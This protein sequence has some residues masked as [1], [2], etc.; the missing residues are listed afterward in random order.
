MPRYSYHARDAKGSSQSGYIDAT[1]EADALRQL[2]GEGFTVTDI[3]IASEIVDVEQLRTRQAARSVETEEVIAFS[4]QMSV[5]LET[6]VPVSEALGAFVKQSK[7][8]GFRRVVDVVRDRINSGVSFSGAIAEFPRAFPPMMVCLLRASEATGALGTMLGRV[9]DYLGKERRTVKQIKGA[10]TYPAVMVG[11]AL[12]V[13]GFLVTWVLPR[14]SRIYESRS[15]TLPAPTR[16]LMSVSD[17]LINQWLLIAV[18]IGALGG[19]L[20]LIPKTDR[21]RYALDWMKVNA[22]IIGPIFSNFYLSRSARTL[23]TLLSAGVNL[24]EAVQIVRGVT[25]NELWRRFWDDMH[26]AMTSGRDVSEVVLRSDL[27][28][29]STAQMIAAGEKSGR[30]GDVLERIANVTEEDLDES[31]KNSTQ[32]IEPL[33]I[34]FMG[35][36]IGGIAIALLLPIFS[37]GSVMSQ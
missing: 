20:Y 31:I 17:A 21:G 12:A 30:L 1:T 37:M 11:M 23:G 14:F 4:A 16:I 27:F 10:L 35:I 25:N 2:R 6:G 29:P 32:M 8:G 3:S 15:A 24:P 13:T 5:M 36:M 7:A 28:P 34:T 18:G 9:A 22:P 26:S 33:V 19:L